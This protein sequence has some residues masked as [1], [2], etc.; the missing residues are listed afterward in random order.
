MNDS[1]ESNHFGRM[2]F[3]GCFHPLA[4]TFTIIVIVVII[5]LG[6]AIVKDY[7]VLQAQSYGKL[8]EVY[9]ES[10]VTPFV[11]LDMGDRVGPETT[12]S[13]LPSDMVAPPPD[14][15]L[16]VRR[17]DGTPLYSSFNSNMDQIN[18]DRF[19]GPIALNTVVE[20]VTDQAS[21]GEVP[22]S[23]PYFRMEIPISH[24]AT[25]DVV[26][27]SR[28]Y[29]DASEA[30]HER[31]RFE[32]TVWIALSLLALGVLVLLVLNGRQRTQIAALRDA[33]K[34][35][36][37]ENGQLRHLADQVRLEAVQPNE[38]ILNLVAAELHDGPVQLLGLISLMKG[39]GAPSRLPD[40]TTI[41]GLIDQ[42]MTELRRMSAGLILPELDGLDAQGVVKLAAERHLK[43]TGTEVDLN[44]ESSSIALDGCRMICLFRVVQEGLMNALRH[45]GSAPPSLTMR[46]DA[47]ALHLVIR[48][49]PA[50]PAANASDMSR[51]HLGINGMRRRLEVFG[52]TLALNSLTSEISLEI[53]LPLDSSADSRSTK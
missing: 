26:A 8:G 40:G 7:R 4:V 45:G 41:D 22:I 35:L 53:T 13:Q 29:T 19:R 47:D 20:L 38:Q 42:V 14:L 15:L 49:L 27:I 37:V 30:L 32:R 39:E 2:R 9:V 43:L 10:F 25:G 31:W 24:P 21:A 36:T 12:F 23:L 28:I 17:P 34:Q 3:F 5:G 1:S 33:K 48:N 46:L 51:W 52:G 16:E 11:V 6:L 44:L 50:E 18:G